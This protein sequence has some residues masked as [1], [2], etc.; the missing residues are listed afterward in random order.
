MLQPFTKLQPPSTIQ[1]RHHLLSSSTLATICCPCHRRHSLSPPSSTARCHQVIKPSRS[2]TII[3]C[4]THQ[5][6]YRERRERG[7]LSGGEVCARIEG[8]GEDERLGGGGGDELRG[9]V[10]RQ[11]SETWSS[12][13]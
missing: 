9:G 13:P 6:K 10:R 8:G 4:F 7:D 12:S 1:T 3:S 2:A 5:T 11:V